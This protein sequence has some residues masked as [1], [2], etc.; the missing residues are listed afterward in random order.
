MPEHEC[1]A[2]MFEDKSV[3]YLFLC[4]AP[5][6]TQHAARIEQFAVK[7]DALHD[8]GKTP[9]H[10][11]ENVCDRGLTHQIVPFLRDGCFFFANEVTPFETEQTPGL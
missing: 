8:C 2:T 9:G 3:F 4:V 6:S 10:A 7:H 1:V 11:E 5:I